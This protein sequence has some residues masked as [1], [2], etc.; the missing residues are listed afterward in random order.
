[1]SFIKALDVSH[2]QGVIDWP[3]VR[4]A[5]YEIAIIK[6]SGGDAGT[7]VDSKAAVNYINARNA[8][9]EVGTYHF[10]GG[11]DAS[12]EAEYFVNVCSPL[13]ENQVLVLDWEVGHA[14]PVGWCT[15]FVNRVHQL[16]GIW[17]LIY[18]NGSTWN[19]HNWTPVTKN[20]GV[21]VAW[22]DRD[23]NQDLPVNG[24][25]V[26]HQYTSSGAVPGIVGRVDLD[27]WYG[28]VAQFKKYGYHAPPAPQ[29]TPPPNPTPAPTPLPTPIPEPSPT[30]PPILPPSPDPGPL[31]PPTPTPLPITLLDVIREFFMKVLDWLKQ[32]KK[33]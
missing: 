2:Y 15:I 23:P 25:Y 18:F 17:P 9:L 4:K 5:G 24:T 20:C 19:S 12:H 27:A 16:T 26:M 8:G 6:V 30:P 21:W 7:Y 31:P 29:P 1:M 14:D 32:F 33:G 3:A 11:G 22:Y 13:D 28:T 10:A